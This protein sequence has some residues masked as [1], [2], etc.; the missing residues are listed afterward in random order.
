MSRACHITSLASKDIEAIAD[1][2][3][4]QSSLTNADWFL[5]GID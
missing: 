2:L 5:N 4:A 1:Y 3:A